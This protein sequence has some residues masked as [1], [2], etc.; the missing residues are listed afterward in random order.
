MPSLERR[1]LPNTLSQ[2]N[3]KVVRRAWDAHTRRAK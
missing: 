1:E 3:V 2:E